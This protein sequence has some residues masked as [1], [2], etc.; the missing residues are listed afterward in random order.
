M[1]INSESND[2]NVSNSKYPCGTCD[3][4]VNWN[5]KGVAC[6]TCGNWFHKSCQSIGSQSYED[7]NNSNISWHCLICGNPNYSEIAY[8]LFGLE[9]DTVFYK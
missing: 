5:T 4:S 6:E 9:N 7:L 3:R 1:S 8:D 2:T